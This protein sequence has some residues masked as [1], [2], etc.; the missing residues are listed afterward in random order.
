MKPYLLLRFQEKLKIK[1]KK[2]LK[3]KVKLEK[4]S[5]EREITGWTERKVDKKK[6]EK[7]EEFAVYLQVN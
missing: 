6:A 3:E 4:R 1:I 7:K 5:K 2:K